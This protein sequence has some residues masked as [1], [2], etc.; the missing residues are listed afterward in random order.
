MAVKIK[1]KKLDG[2]VSEVIGA[3]LMVGIGVALFSILYFI[4]MSYPFS[5][6]VPSVD[7]VGSI[8]GSNIVLEHRG[9]DSLD[10]NATVSFI[11]GGTRISNTVG[12]FLN[13]TN[14]NHRWDIGE[15]LVYNNSS[16]TNLQVEAT[17]IDTDSNSIMI[18]TV[19]QEGKT[20]TIPSLDTSVDTIS[21]YHQTS[22]PLTV[23]AIG[24]PG[25]NNVTLYYRWSNDNWTVDWTT[26]TYDDFEGGFGNYSDGGVNCSLYT[27]GTYAHQGSKAADIQ[28]NGGNASSFYHTNG[29]D[30]HSPGYTCITISFWFRSEGLSDGHD[31]F[32]EYYDGAIWQ[33]VASFVAG[34]DFVNDQFYY[35]IVWINE[36]SYT[37][38]SD[39]KIKFR[40]DAQN[41]SNDVYIDQ[42]YVNATVGEGDSENWYDANWIYRK[43][44]NITGQAGAGPNYQ[45]LLMI[46]ETSGVSGAYFNLGGHSSNFPS[47]K[48]IGGDLRFTNKS[49]TTSLDFWVEDVSGTAPNRLAKVW[50][51]VKDSLNSSTNIYC[52]YGNP[53]ASNASNGTNTFNF[54]DNF[55]DN[56]IDAS[57]WTTYQG[58]W[59][60]T[61]G[62]MR[63]TSTGTAD[64]KKCIA[65]SAP[66]SNY[67]AIRA[68]VRPEAG[69]D[70]D[71]RAGLSIKTSA[72][73]GES[74]NYV[75][76]DFVTKTTEQ[77]LDDHVAWGTSYTRTAWSFGTWYWFEIYHDGTNVRGR[78]WNI[79]GTPGA[80]NSWPRSGR[81]GYLALNGGSMG[82]TASFDD[83]FVR[84]CI[85]I[86][87]SYSSAGAEETYIGGGEGHNWIIYTGDTNPDLNS[88]WSWSFNFPK[89]VG[90][91]EFYSI[92]RYAGTIEGAPVS[93]DARCQKM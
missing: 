6:S 15:Q 46:G 4:V 11:V 90:Y 68:K 12:F 59:S 69:T 40:C 29:V 78:V 55:D 36:T 92:G 5:P 45:V 81:P 38:P 87:P 58:T 49:G 65:T 50:V 14:G 75:F 60:E 76:H 27:G 39:M 34:T 88:P 82:E 20:T 67:Y 44:I 61:G 63:Q 80:F 71:G 16:M 56:S 51:E 24:D 21:P 10:Q 43:K 31:F 9:G 25:L 22:S 85:A 28:G 84:K 62:I 91:Y 52:Y 89:G 74:Y 72:A 53:S 41:N 64:P 13:D 23:Y 32:V 19:L 93:A 30:V 17:V 79:G 48:N 73:N 70:A 83:V 26:L 47:G 18:M 33:T 77:F 8:E 37:F 54:F 66:Q 35:E 57:K 42:I 1:W 7:I 2:A 3:I 86:E